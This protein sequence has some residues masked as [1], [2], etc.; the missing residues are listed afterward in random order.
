M[1]QALPR[2]VLLD[3][4]ALQD[5]VELGLR[6]VR[7]SPRTYPL[8]DSQLRERV[9]A[10]LAIG[11]GVAAALREKWPRE[12]AAWVARALGV[13]LWEE[14]EDEDSPPLGAE[15][16]DGSEVVGGRRRLAAFVPGHGITVYRRG[17]EVLAAAICRLVAECGVKAC[18]QDCGNWRDVAL[19]LLVA[20]ELFHYLEERSSA[21][22]PGT[23]GMLRARVSLQLGYPARFLGLRFRAAIP[24][25]SEVAA[26]SFSSAFVNL[27]VCAIVVHARL[28]GWV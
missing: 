10:A 12:S 11:A 22:L 20:H 6:L 7:S 3:N 13:S 27:P 9:A 23:L 24:E 28:M 25:L 1:S 19:E 8:T 4:N 18:R 14:D 21:A 26:H 16:R 2:G 17:R 5:P 15:L